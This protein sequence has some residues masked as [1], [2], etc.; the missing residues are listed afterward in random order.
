MDIKKSN[1]LLL[2]VVIFFLIIIFYVKDSESIGLIVILPLIFLII[3]IFFIIL[4]SITKIRLSRDNEVSSKKT[5]ILSIFLILLALILLL[6]FFN[7]GRPDMLH[8]KYNYA[9]F[10]LLSSFTAVPLLLTGILI[11]IYTIKNKK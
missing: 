11:L 6:I 2:V 5:F 4:N 7:A 9:L 8:Q 3:G 1:K 10:F